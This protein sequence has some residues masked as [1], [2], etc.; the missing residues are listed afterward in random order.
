MDVGALRNCILST[1]S[2]NADLR[3]QAELDLKYVRADSVRRM[4]YRTNLTC[5]CRQKSNRVFLMHYS[6]S[7][8]RNHK[9]R[10]LCP[11]RSDDPKAPPTVDTDPLLCTAAVYLKNR[12][13]RAWQP[14]EEYPNQ[15]PIREE[16]KA[17]FR[18]RLLPVLAS[19][20]PQIRQQ[21]IPALHRILQYDFPEK[22]PDFMDITMRLLSTND[23]PSVF[24]GLQCLLAIC[25]VY[26]F[27][28]TE[29]RGDF[30]KIVALSFPRLLTIG[31]GLVNETSNDAGEMLR[32]V[33]KS[34]KHATF[35][36]GDLAGESRAV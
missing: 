35:V 4:P 17:G 7:F 21:L 12:V 30:D 13:T 8:K 1:L 18:N 32:I 5:A 15:T 27:K 19:A 10:F 11:V 2:P 9:L 36:S 20:Q 26:R 23:A 22:W 6:I 24:A 31:E 34:F 33:I 16:E 25:R 29:S 14:G 28:A 3:Q